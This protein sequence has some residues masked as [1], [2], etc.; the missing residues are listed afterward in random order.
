MWPG[1][2]HHLH[3][4][5]PGLDE[6]AVDHSAALVSEIVAGGN[7]VLGIDGAGEFEATG[8]V[9]VVDVG[10]EHVGDPH[11]VFGSE[12]QDAVDVA[13]RVDH[14]AHVTGADQIAAIAQTGGFDDRHVHGVLL[15]RR[16]RRDGY[17]CR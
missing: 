3:V 1:G 16:T 11:A 9:V 5:R 13:L 2:V 17:P 12:L 6:V 8:D 15:R 10:L 7:D 14:H 4:D